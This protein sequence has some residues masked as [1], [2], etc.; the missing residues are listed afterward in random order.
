MADVDV[1][2]D[3]GRGGQVGEDG[4]TL[5]ASIDGLPQCACKVAAVAEAVI[6]VLRE[7]PHDHL[8]HL[9]GESRIQG[10]WVG[11]VWS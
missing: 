9:G 3:L 5:G 8:T 4:R 10:R 7:R 1:D 11:R 6:R 2:A